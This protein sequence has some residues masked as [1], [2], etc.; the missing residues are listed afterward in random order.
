[1]KL[2]KEVFM[3]LPVCIIVGYGQGNGQGIARAFGRAG[4]GLGLLPR[5]LDK[6]AGPLA[7]LEAAGCARELIAA[8]AGD[9][10]SLT[11]D[12]GTVRDHLGDAEV[13]VNNAVALRM[14]PQ[15]A[16][17]TDQLVADFRGSGV[18]AG[19]VT[20]MGLAAAG[21]AFDPDR[22]GEAFVTAYRKPLDQFDPDIQ[23]RGAENAET[24]LS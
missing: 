22:I 21:N 8:D 24:G 20:L 2:Q 13:L 7:E 16:T 14:A 18:R 6:L 19:T 10:Q 12:L 15:T 4:F 17:T 11:A 3:A 9:E 1:M 23:F 5:S